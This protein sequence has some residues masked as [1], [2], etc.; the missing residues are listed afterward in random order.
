MLRKRIRAV[1][2]NDLEMD[3]VWTFVG[4]KQRRLKPE[5][6]GRTDLGDAYCFIALERTTKLVVAWHLGKRDN[7]NTWDF[8]TK[9]RDATTGTFQLSSDAFGAYRNAV[10]I[11]LH[12]R[13]EYAQLI[14]L[15]GSLPGD[16]EYYRPA[17]ILGTIKAAVFGNPNPARICTSHIERKNGTLRQ[18]CK[19]LTRLTYAFSKK[20]ENLESALAL[21]FAH[22]NYC[23]P[24][25]SLKVTPA[26]ESGLSDHVWSLDELLMEVGQA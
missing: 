21:H 2:V 6:K 13:A 16:R 5:E 8:I 14:K 19:R 11:G 26:M 22:Y 10:E 12:D 15:Y 25:G 20:W 17:K 9:V 24:H 23:R 18:W 7:P 3:E 1:A 4:K